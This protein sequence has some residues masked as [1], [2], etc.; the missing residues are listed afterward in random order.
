MYSILFR[1]SIFKALALCLLLLFGVRG[2]GYGQRVLHF[3]DGVPNINLSP[4]TALG[5]PVGTA[6]VTDLANST[7]PNPQNFATIEVTALAG[8][9]S[10]QIQL[11]F[12]S[13]VPI[14][15]TVFVRLSGTANGLLSGLGG[16]LRISAINGGTALD[17]SDYK[18]I[19]DL[20][21]I[22]GS[23]Y[24]AIKSTKTFTSVRIRV[25]TG[26][27]LDSRRINVHHAFYITGEDICH[28]P[29]YSTIG[30]NGLTL[31]LLGNGAKVINPSRAI[32]SDPTNYSEL[33][34]GSGITIGLGN[35]IY[36][37]VYFPESSPS[38]YGFRIFIRSP[39]S[40]VNLSLFSGIRVSA[41]NESGAMVYQQTLDQVLG[42]DLLGLAGGQ[43][44]PVDIY[45]SGGQSFNRIRVELGK[46]LDVNVLGAGLYFY[47]VRYIPPVPT[48]STINN[49][50]CEGNNVTLSVASPNPSMNYHWYNSTNVFLSNGPSFLI[51]ASDLPV[52]GSPF[53]FYVSAEKP[54]CDEEESSKVPVTVIVYPKPSPPHITAN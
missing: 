20:V 18:V 48:I 29:L 14:G 24:W 21:S 28:S 50:T 49:I 33:S 53:I 45:P 39:Q 17:T 38:N 52:T 10:A 11:N 27:L 42:I 22:E 4:A 23:Y 6:T 54:N 47:G 19:K 32:D 7:D 37:D 3:A 1:S 31:D 15:N 25:Q 13:P 5:L 16:D 35:S 9:S 2:E 12:L 26:V 41:F 36:Q 30:T 51:Q 40:V 43:L 46:F 44:I 34:L 8:I